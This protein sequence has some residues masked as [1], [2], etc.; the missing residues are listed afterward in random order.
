MRVIRVTRNMLALH[1]HP[2]MDNGGVPIEKYVIE[3]R[4][5]DRSHWSAAGTCSNDITAYSVTDLLENTPY[6]FRI[7]AVNAYGMSEA[8]ETTKPIVPKRIFGEYSWQQL[9]PCICVFCFVNSDTRFFV[10]LL[11]PAFFY[12]YL[13][14]PLVHSSHILTGHVHS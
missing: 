7:I 6:Y 10:K 8:L 12:S 1:W 3:K 14:I 4:E 9:M 2:P 11:S 13:R 5:A